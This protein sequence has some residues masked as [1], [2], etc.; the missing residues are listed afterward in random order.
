MQSK[1]TELSLS[2][3]LEIAGGA[4]HWD[5]TPPLEG[6]R[7]LSRADS[8]NLTD[9]KKHKLLFVEEV[10]PDHHQVHFTRLGRE[11]AAAHGITL[12]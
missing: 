4:K 7:P 2:L 9:L 1:L 8:G 6:M 12:R 3:F 5:G 10:D 11:L